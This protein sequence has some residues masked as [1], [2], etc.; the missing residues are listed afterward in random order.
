MG[1][2]YI[3]T[4]KQNGK[5]YIGQTKQAVE[6]RWGNGVGYETQQFGHHL[7]ME[8]VAADPSKVTIADSREIIEEAFS[9]LD[10]KVFEVADVALD[11]CE[12]YLIKV[13]N[14]TNSS[15]GYNTKNET[16]KPLADARSCAALFGEDLRAWISSNISEEVFKDSDDFLAAVYK[17]IV[18]FNSG[19]EM[20]RSMQLA[21]KKEVE[22]FIE[23]A[24][25]ALEEEQQKFECEKSKA[26][27]LLGVKFQEIAKKE[28]ELRKAYEEINL[29]RKNLFNEKIAFEN[30]RAE[31]EER[32]EAFENEVSER[33]ARLDEREA[34]IENKINEEVSK[35][36]KELEESYNQKVS[37]LNYVQVTC[38]NKYNE[39]KQKLEAEFEAKLNEQKNK[40]HLWG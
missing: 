17:E 9:K 16:C 28:E 3:H 34:S 37:A 22:A 4:N 11:F 26:R 1:Y 32:K 31:L 2:I 8:A 21:G 33:E 19:E 10:H 40:W 29:E 15:F 23:R 5:R 18:I 36:Q 25:K 24:K 14:T 13:L 7:L 12:A 38:I 35:K 6:Y 27:H 39:D 20:L 30:E